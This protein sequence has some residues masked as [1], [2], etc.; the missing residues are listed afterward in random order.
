VS[1]IVR[2]L[3]DTDDL[4]FATGAVDTATYG[5]V[6]ILFRPLA[7]YDSTWRTLLSLWDLGGAEVGS[8]TINTGN[9]VGWWAGGSGVSGPTV[10]AG[11]LHLLVVRK[12]T[13]TANVRFSLLNLSTG[14]THEDSAGTLADWTAPTGGGLHTNRPTFLDWGPGS[15][16][17]AMAVWA[18]ELPWSADASGDSEIEAAGLE[19]HLDNWRDAAP[20]AGWAFNQ[21]TNEYSIEDWTLGRADEVTVGVG[22]PTAVTDIDFTYEDIGLGF[23]SRNHLRDTQTEAGTGGT[24]YD[25]S[26]TQGTPSTLQSDTVNSGSFTEVFRWTRTVGTD[27]GSTLIDT[28]VQVTAISSNAQYQWRVARVDSSG[29]EQATSDYS[30]GQSTTGIKIASFVLDTTWAAGDRLVLALELRKSSGGGNRTVTVAVNDGDCWVEFEV[31]LATQDITPGAVTVTA[32]AGTLTLSTGAVDITP[33]PV[34]V[35][36]TPGTLAVGLTAAPEATTVTVVP[37]AVTLTTVVG[38]TPAPT[39]VTTT[40]GTVTVAVAGGDIQDITPAAVTLT[41]SAGT[42]TA[43]LDVPLVGATVTATAGTA[44]VT[45]GAVDIVP[46]PVTVTATPGAP[47]VVTG[48]LQPAAVVVTATPGAM[49]VTTGVVDITP[50]AA[51]VTTTPG[52]LAVDLDVPLAGATVTATPGTVTVGVT[53]VNIIPVALV[54]TVTPGAVVIPLGVDAPGAF[55]VSSAPARLVATA[56]TAAM[57]GG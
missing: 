33:A 26:E 6:A 41:A 17:V 49:T 39:T 1:I 15:D 48:G 34:T 22:T 9:K 23:A 32:G 3:S 57:R 21:S 37:G 44:T 14:W 51:G 13:G 46:A 10:T 8:V 7:A 43:D 47:T 4:T 30:A 35:T 16:L 31:V 54:V 2:R 19:D 12:A 56:P 42:L 20:S 28:Q 27:V 40:P 24:V 29:V 18:D 50:A 53:A 11:D 45:A 5:T 25:L 52:T 36:A 55:V 38:I